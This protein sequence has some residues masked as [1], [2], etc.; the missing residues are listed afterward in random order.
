MANYSKGYTPPS[1]LNSAA[2]VRLLQQ[3]LKN[4]GYQIGAGPTGVWD[5]GT[6][7][8]YQKYLAAAKGALPAGTDKK[9][10]E[11][12]NP[13]LAA[14]AGAP[15]AYNTVGLVKAYQRMYGLDETGAWDEATKA[16]YNENRK[17]AVMND[18]LKRY[19]EDTLAGYD[20]PTT[21]KTAL[22]KEIAGY[23][24]PA[25]D[26]AIAERKK[27]TAQNQAAVDVDAYSRGM[28]PSTWVTDAKA[29]QMDSEA[30][31]VTNM[32]N[33]Y[34][35]SLTQALLEQLNANKTQELTAKN[36]AYTMALK[37]Y[38]LAQAQR[39]AM[40]PQ[41]SYSGGGGGGGGYSYSSGSSSGSYSGSGKSAPKK[42]GRAGDKIATK[43]PAGSKSNTRGGN[44]ATTN[45]L[46]KYASQAFNYGMAV[47]SAKT[48]AQKAAAQAKYNEAAKAARDRQYANK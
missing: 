17:L 5:A 14:V 35:A 20:L 38:E 3:Y 47:N 41:S 25:Y 7:G 13:D 48:A 18:E 46:N 33:N 15:E 36:N 19:Y 30:D 23:L 40:A 12:S 24:R 10:P 45:D 44:Y 1:G 8:A 28:G 29:R 43:T 34:A 21:D 4:A 9:P 31:D 2:D 26:Q 37:L 39:A 6:N 16:K 32:E 42:S 27:A 22:Q 11:A